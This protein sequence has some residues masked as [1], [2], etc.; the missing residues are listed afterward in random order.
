MTD[1]SIRQTAEWIVDELAK[2]RLAESDGGDVVGDTER[3]SCVDAVERAL[4]A[5]GAYSRELLSEGDARGFAFGGDED[6]VDRMTREWP[7]TDRVTMAIWEGS[8]PVCVAVKILEA[9]F[10][11]NRVSTDDIELEDVARLAE[12]VA[13]EDPD[14]QVLS[15]DAIDILVDGDEADIEELAERLPRV[16]AVVGQVYENL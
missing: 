9:L 4:I 3:A 8:H 10:V 7:E 2:A 12:A 11:A 15:A 6:A 14:R 13:A 5:D 1:E 16:R